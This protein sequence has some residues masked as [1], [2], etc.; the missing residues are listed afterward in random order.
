MNSQTIVIHDSHTIQRSHS[1]GTRLKTHLIIQEFEQV[2]G[3]KDKFTEV[4]KPVTYL[5]TL[6]TH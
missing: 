3:F 1:P 2:I 5:T 6:C 4:I